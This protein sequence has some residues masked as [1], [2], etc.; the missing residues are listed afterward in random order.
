M[1]AYLAPLAGFLTAI[2]GADYKLERSARA[3]DEFYTRY[4]RETRFYDFMSGA[5]GA[6]V[7]AFAEIVVRLRYAGSA[8]SSPRRLA[9]RN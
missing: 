5:I 7:G 9:T 2:R 8:V 6:V 4:D 1:D 3:E